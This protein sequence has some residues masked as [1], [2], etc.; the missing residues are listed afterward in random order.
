[1]KNWL[2]VALVAV[3]AVGG[4]VA[5]AQSSR[6]ANVEIRVWEST[7]D[8]TRNYI[9]ARPEGG[10]WSTLGTIP[11]GTGDA[12]A[13][14]ETSNGRFRYSDITLA[15]PLPDGAAR[16]TPTPSPTATAAPVAS[17]PTRPVL[18]RAFRLNGLSYSAQR[19]PIDNSLTTAVASSTEYRDAYGLD[20]RAIFVILCKS[21]GELQAGLSTDEYHR[22]GTITYRID[23]NAS[24]QETWVPVGK[25]L[26]WD[27]ADRMF[28]R[29]RGA[30]RLLIRTSEI[31]LLTFDVAGFHQTPVQP[32]ME[33]C[34]RPGWR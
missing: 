24:V 33:N 1:M 9:S 11:L 30:S 17:G 18:G 32:N 23:G 16:S 5:F 25:N 27:P 14:E 8:P 20:Q 13:Y 26:F 28:E 2:I 21:D 6:T 29:L 34:G 15:V 22:S 31:N 4:A 10:S 7:S 3:I 12:S 19:D